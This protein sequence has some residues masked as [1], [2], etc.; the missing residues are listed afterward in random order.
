MHPCIVHRE[1][2]LLITPKHPILLA[3]PNALFNYRLSSLNNVQVVVTDEADMLITGGGDEIWEILSFFKG[4]DSL[5]MKK[6][7]KRLARRRKASRQCNATEDEKL[8]SD[9]VV[10]TKIDVKNTLS[11]PDD[12]C[13]QE[14][15]ATS[16]SSK[17][18]FVFAAATLPNHGP[19][20]ALTVLK[21]WVPDAEFVSTDLAHRT[22]PTVGIFYVRVH[23]VD[24]LPELLQCLNSLVGVIEYPFTSTEKRGSKEVDFVGEGDQEETAEVCP[25]KGGI[26]YLDLHKEQIED[27]AQQGNEMESFLEPMIVQNLRV[28]IF[29]NSAKAATRAFNFLSGNEEID[30]SNSVPWKHVTRN[31]VTVTTWQVEHDSDSTDED[32]AGQ[33][34]TH[35]GSKDVWIGRVGLI[36]KKLPLAQR[37]ETLNKF[38]SGELKV[39]ICTDLASRGLDIQD[40]SHVI[41]LDFA[42]N[43]AQVLHR[44][45][46]TARA[47]A[48]GKGRNSSFRGP[49]VSLRFNLNYY[50]FHSPTKI[51]D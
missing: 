12:E 47:G 45:G 19:K 9:S 4:V 30:E 49:G 7:Q 39:L 31:G 23:E 18:Q 25:G 28:L 37:T 41:Q 27:Q 20:S 26:D 35:T 22:V 40:V 10:Q 5:K 1:S 33:L 11:G 38:K 32:S 43:A 16:A 29:A 36:H 48:K 14:D 21:E 3:T 6:R 13:I 15:K 2:K 46:R 17:R 51:F 24:K 50:W 44:T 8:T 34:V 42:P